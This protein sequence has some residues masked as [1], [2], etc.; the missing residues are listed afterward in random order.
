MVLGN[1]P[2]PS[3]HPIT[4]ALSENNRTFHL[5]QQQLQKH[6]YYQMGDSY[7]AAKSSVLQLKKPENW[8]KIQILWAASTKV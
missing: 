2:P 3:L 4:S 8:R 5:T 7:N 1:P 6:T